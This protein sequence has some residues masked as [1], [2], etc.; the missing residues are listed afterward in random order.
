MREVS[1][2]MPADIDQARR[3]SAVEV[4]G[5]EQHEDGHH[6]AIGQVGGAACQRLR[7][8]V[9]HLRKQIFVEFVENTENFY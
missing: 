3:T 2:H 8:Y 5:V 9:F 6:L 7:R 1:T 4:A